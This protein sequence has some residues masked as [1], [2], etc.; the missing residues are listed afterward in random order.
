MHIRTRKLIGTVA[1]LVLVIVWALLAMGF[2][3]MFRSRATI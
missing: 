2:A 1:L 3:Q